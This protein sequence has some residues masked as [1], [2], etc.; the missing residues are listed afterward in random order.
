[1][2]R[3]RIFNMKTSASTLIS[4]KK[5]AARTNQKPLAKPSS[6]SQPKLKLKSINKRKNISPKKVVRQD[7]SSDSASTSSSS[8]SECERP[9]KRKS[10]IVS[11]KLTSKQISES[12][13]DESDILSDESDA[14]EGRIIRIPVEREDQHKYYK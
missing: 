3:K 13:S 12:S 8:E 11:K 5:I 1:M 4:S 10:R 6:N 14:K 9:T 7:L 2:K